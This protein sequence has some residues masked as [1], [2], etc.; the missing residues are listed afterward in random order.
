MAKRKRLGQDE[1][2]SLYPFL[3]TNRAPLSSEGEA[4]PGG[5]G[6]YLPHL[7]NMIPGASMPVQP[8]P[9]DEIPI[10]ERQNSVDFLQMIPQHDLNELIRIYQAKNE[11]T[12]R[13]GQ[14]HKPVLV[15]SYE[16]QLLGS[17]PNVSGQTDPMTGLRS[18]QDGAAEA[19]FDVDAPASGGID[20]DKAHAA[21]LASA[22]ALQES[23]SKKAGTTITY[24]VA[25]LDGTKHS[26]VESLTKKNQEISTTRLT[27]NLNNQVTAGT[28]FPTTEFETWWEGEQARNQQTGSNQKS[29]G[30]FTK[31]QV[32]SLFDKKIAELAKTTTDQY[33]K[34]WKTEAE[35]NAS[36]ENINGAKEAFKK[37][38]Q[39]SGQVYA[40]DT[41]ETASNRGVWDKAAAAAVDPTGKTQQTKMVQTDEGEWVE[42]QVSPDEEGGIINFDKLSEDDKKK[43]FLETMGRVVEGAKGEINTFADNISTALQGKT[44]AELEALQLVDLITEASAN[45]PHL[46]DEQKRGLAQAALDLAIREARFTLTPEEVAKW[47]TKAPTVDETKVAWGVAPVIATA[48]NFQDWWDSKGGPGTPEAPGTYPDETSARTAWE[49]AQVGQ[50]V[51]APTVAPVDFEEWWKARGGKEGQYPDRATAEAQWKKEQ[52]TDVTKTTI[53]APTAPTAATVGTVDE[54]TET[55]I[56]KPDDISA[57]TVERV[58]A[59]PRTK[60]ADFGFIQGTDVV[61]YDTSEIDILRSKEGDFYRILKETIEG[62]RDS[63]AQQ[64]LRSET[65]RMM[66]LMLGTVAGADADP[67]KLRGIQNLWSDQQQNMIRES[68]QLRSKEEQDA[69][70]RMLQLFE[71]SGTREAKL[72]LADMEARRITAIEQGKLDQARKIKD[73]EIRLQEVIVNASLDMKAREA[74][75]NAELQ[76]A[77]AN[78]N[79]EAAR[80]ITNQKTKL[81]IALGNAELE[82]G[83]TLAKFNADLLV[84]IENGQLDQARKIFNSEVA[85]RKQMKNADLEL[86]VQL[87]K[88][89]TQKDLAIANGN[90]ELATVLGNLQG[91]LLIATTNPE[92]AIKSRAMD[93][94]LAMASYEGQMQMAGVDVKIDENALDRELKTY[95]SDSAISADLEGIA[96]KID[97]QMTIAKM[98]ET[99]ALMEIDVKKDYNAILALAEK[100][101]ANKSLY[102]SLLNAVAT[103]I[104]AYASFPKSD[105]RAKK[106]I[107]SGDPEIERFLD[108]LNAYQ[109]EYRDPKAA[110]A[111]EG[112]FLGIMAQDAERGGPMGQ[113]FV[114]DTPE[115]KK[116]DPGH[117]M[118]AI[119]AAQ[120]NLHERTKKLEGGA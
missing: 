68:T 9:M 80:K 22:A 114:V 49:A 54:I 6:V 107:S 111:E 69:Q 81:D 14:L 104:A 28:F 101:K 41:W 39:E 15:N 48:T 77:I 75:L 94:A 5:P 18:F 31:E 67:R 110:H 16:E 61:L 2:M 109:Y 42:V 120:A 1:Y 32:K 20:L 91:S 33:G 56:T 11:G 95:L 7:P 36:D 40:D 58:K 99:I 74:N 79:I 87:E 93:N 96:L 117:G 38:I 64:Q 73:A 100:N 83:A 89:Q 37:W 3:D 30:N 102:S 8:P 97:A 65:E 55:K 44:Q 26:S 29:W 12:M 19:G 13:S 112:M 84:A 59:I 53:K 85:L 63:P 66:R 60:I 24:S 72:A 86:A 10:M 62:K 113:S 108:A 71:I 23:E 88:L 4:V 46:S 119:L 118:A 76:T 17:L 98:E 116:L 52:V 21:E 115:G 25:D 90:M 82:Q 57:P 92:L 43:I 50:D 47:S 105:I 51:F 45:V 27:N 78:G 34:I 103:G 106:N 35:K 70:A